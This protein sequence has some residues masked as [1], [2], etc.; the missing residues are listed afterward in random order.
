[1]SIYFIDVQ[2]TAN[3]KTVQC[4]TLNTCDK[5]K[6]EAA[7]TMMQAS[8]HAKHIT[9]SHDEKDGFTQRIR[10]VILKKWQRDAAGVWMHAILPVGF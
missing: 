6:A 2:F 8:D 3:D 7:V 10:T 1:M 5:S 9:L 4:V